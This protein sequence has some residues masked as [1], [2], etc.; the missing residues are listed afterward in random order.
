MTSYSQIKIAIL[1][2]DIVWSNSEQN[3]QTVE[4]TLLSLDSDC[5]ILV[6]PELFNTGFIQDSAL[7]DEWDEDKTKEVEMRI[8]KLSK[9][10]RIA[11]A[12]SMLAREYGKLYNRGFFIEPSGETTYYDKRHLFSLSPEAKLF[13]RG[14]SLPSVI[15]YRGWNISMVICYDLRFPVWCR[16]IESRSDIIIVPANW[17]ISRGYAWKHLLIARAIENQCIVVGANRS[18]EDD[19]GKYNGLSFVYDATGHI[20]VSSN[21]SEGTNVIYT[22]CTKEELFKTRTMLPFG[23]DADDFIINL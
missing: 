4:Q 6:L 15:R 11:I 1:S 14:N 18:G 12:G 3:L 8:K 22:T 10:H 19:Y 23:K 13:A 20:L 7:L 5:D 9:Q 21:N 16:N 17:P 2:L